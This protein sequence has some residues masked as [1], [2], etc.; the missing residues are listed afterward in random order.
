MQLALQTDISLENARQPTDLTTSVPAEQN[1][2]KITN[3]L[4][5]N[6]G[7]LLGLILVLFILVSFPPR[8]QIRGAPAYYY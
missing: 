6:R 8:P 5:G 2:H 1:L 3:C 4:T 7:G